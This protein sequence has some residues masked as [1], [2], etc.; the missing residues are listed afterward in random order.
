MTSLVALTNR[1]VNNVVNL[2][3]PVVTMTVSL[4]SYTL[5]QKR[6]LD[7]ATVF[8]SMGI[9]EMLKDL[10]GM[11]F[12]MVNQYITSGVSLGRINKF[13]NETDMIDAFSP[14]AQLD[15]QQTPEHL[16]A[17]DDGLIRLKNATFAWGKD[18]DDKNMINHRIHI[19]DVTFRKGEVNLIT[20]PTGS[21]KSS[22]LKA[23]VGELYFEPQPG[24]FFHLPRQ[25]GVSYA[26][27]ESWVLSGTIRENILFGSP[28]D[29][30]RYRKVIHDCALETDLKLF[31]DGDQTEIGEKGVTLSGGQKARITLARAIY[32]HTATVLLDDIFSAL[33]TLTSRFILDNLFRGDLVKG[34]TV[35]LI[36]HHVRLAAPVASYMVTLDENGQVTHAGPIDSTCVSSSSSVTDIVGAKEQA[37]AVIDEAPG[38]PQSNGKIGGTDASSGNKLIKDEEKS[39]GRISR[40]ALFSFFSTFGGPTFWILFWSLLFV[41]QVLAA[42]QPYWLGLWARAYRSSSTPASVDPVFWLGWYVIWVVLGTLSV[43]LATVLYYQGSMRASRVVHSRLVDKIFGAPLRFLDTTP[44]G[45]II[46][47]FTKDMKQIDGNFTETAIGV[48]TMTMG[49][50]IKF[51]AVVALVP[52]FTLPA[53]AIGLVGAFIGELYIHGQLSVKREMSNAKSPLFSHLSSSINGI[54]SIRAYGAQEQIKRETQVKADK[55]TRAARAFYNLNRWVTIRI[56]M[57][58]GVFSA[59]LASFLIYL[60]P[61]DPSD[62]G[63][64]LQQ[65]IS[66]SIMIL[67]WVRMVNEMEV[68]GNSVERIEDYMVIDQEPPSVP[69]R[70]PPASWPTS[71]EVILHDLSAKYSDDGPEVL[72]GLNV[73][74]KSG[75]RIGIVGRTGSGKSTLTVALLRMIPTSGEVYI[76]GVRTDTINLHDLRSHVT[77]IP[78]D[79]VLLSGTLRFNLDPFGEHADSVLLDAMDASGLGQTSSADAPAAGASTP[80]RVTLDTL[81][82]AGGSNLSQGQRQLVA[83]ARALVRQSKV[84]IL[85]EATASVDFAGDQIIQKSI[86]NL[87]P[88]TTVLTVAHRLATVMD[89]DRILVLDKGRVVEFDAPQV[90]RDK[91]DSYFASLVAAMEG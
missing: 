55:Y 16:A 90:L 91:K 75:E 13:L 64:A 58:G 10:F 23:L 82:T 61:L 69:E 38:A 53:I 80:Q 18:S 67:W 48:F 86:R 21:G 30:A 47:R 66:F 84:L 1:R 70:T 46:S 51:V 52:L 34:R 39:E 28:Y 20:G 25:G 72:H 14:G 87:P 11:T 77:I 71:G 4:A 24:S 31:D 5:I 3:L 59:L 8:T 15:F 63:F 7:A 32:A 62:A 76:D 78:Q 88:G 68:Q 22:L 49:M 43:A 41:S 42:L 2:I 50:V 37:E 79:P 74:I 27:Q 54:V 57:L 19:P 44:V 36:T 29:E 9:F 35:V 17:I 81:I 26:A 85:D 45:R 33:D 65:A 60:S 6:P 89:Y 73:H 83:L 56:D 40:R 12:W